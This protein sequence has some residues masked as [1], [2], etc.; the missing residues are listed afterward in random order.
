M[1]RGPELIY[2]LHPSDYT[3]HSCKRRHHV[4]LDTLYWPGSTTPNFHYQSW[5]CTV[6]AISSNIK[7]K[8]STP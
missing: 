3:K 8:S 2:G 1:Q 7:Y 6:F 5:S 4:E